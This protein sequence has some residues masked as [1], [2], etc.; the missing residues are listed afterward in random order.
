MMTQS[1]NH[2]AASDDSADTRSDEQLQGAHAERT[3][4]NRRND[5]TPS[6]HDESAQTTPSKRKEDAP[7]SDRQI[8]QAHEDISKRLIDTDRRG[9]PDDVPHDR[10]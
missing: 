10:Q 8:N 6:E 7:E 4:L 1:V 9:I 2:E 3:S 5:K